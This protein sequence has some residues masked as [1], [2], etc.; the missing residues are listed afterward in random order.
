M[1]TT[2]Y[3]LTVK[4]LPNK[5]VIKSYVVTSAKFDFKAYELRVLNG[6]IAFN[7]QII[8]G[9]EFG[10]KYAFNKTLFGDA[11]YTM[12]LRAFFKDE[13]D[14]NYKEVKK[15]L[16][17]LRARTLEF[18]NKDKKIWIVTGF[19]ERALVDRGTGIVEFRLHPLMYEALLDFSRGARVFELRVAMMF[20]SVYAMRFYELISG[21]NKPIN[22]A[23]HTLK[24]MFCVEEKYKLTADFVRY[25]IE[26]ARQELNAKSPWTF[27]Y[28]PYKHGRKIAGWM[29]TPVYQ[30][31][32]RDPQLERKELQK[33]VNLSWDLPREVRVYLHDDYLFSD[34]EIKRNIDVFKAMHARGSLLEWLA[35]G[36]K[37]RALRAKNP[38]GYLINA[39]KKEIKGNYETTSST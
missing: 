14:D 11:D 19:I 25:V 33:Q 28:T 30:P 6:I 9:V 34:E 22:Y 16:N 24:T 39:I 7:Q 13:N 10:N 2:K 20:N 37:A 8:A 38:K 18:E 29:F 35:G 26:V 27:T 5:D 3:L 21:Q 36:V 12:P 32:F 23:V 15:A 1:F 4:L 31:Q 17:S